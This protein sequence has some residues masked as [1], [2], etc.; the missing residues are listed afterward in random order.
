MIRA[1][2]NM[3]IVAI[4]Q[5]GIS[6]AIAV[7]QMKNSLI[8]PRIQRDAIFFAFPAQHS[9]HRPDAVAKTQFIFGSRQR[10]GEQKD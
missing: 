8:N 6:L 4:S 10:L 1:V 3:V 2:E 5:T 7:C 9:R